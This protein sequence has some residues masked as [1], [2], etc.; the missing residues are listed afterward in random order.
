MVSF[1]TRIRAVISERQT[2]QAAVAKRA[3]ISAGAVSE[4]VHDITSPDNVKA[5]PLLK[6]TAYLGVNAQWLLTGKGARDDGRVALEV[7]ESPPPQYSAWPFEVLDY[8]LVR[9]L[10]PLELARV[11]GAWL[12]AAKQLGFSLAKPGVA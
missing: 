10:R 5:A 1:G 8:G 2:S 9:Q 7:A 12:L 4:W 3:G 6:A 11:E